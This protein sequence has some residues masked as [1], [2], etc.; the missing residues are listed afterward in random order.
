MKHTALALLTTKQRDKDN[1][2]TSL[3]TI[4]GIGPKTVQLL[5]SHF[6]SV[7]Q[8]T[9][10]KKQELISLIGKNKAEKILKN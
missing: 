6:G 1:L 9:Q 7:K 3:D 8:V 5:L 4:K 10:A 2:G